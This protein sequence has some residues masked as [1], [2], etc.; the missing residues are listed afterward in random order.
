MTLRQQALDE[1]ASV[2]ERCGG[3][4]IDGDWSTDARSIDITEPAQGVRIGAIA[5]GGVE[6]VDRAVAAARRAFETG[7]WRTMAPGERTRIL[8]RAGDMIEARA[9]AI[10]RLE[11]LDV[12]MPHAKAMGLVCGTAEMFRYSAGWCTKLHGDAADMV[13]P[14]GIFHSYTRRE[15]AGVAALITPWNTPFALAGNKSATALS[16]GCTVVLKPAEDTPLSAMALAEVLREAGVPPGVFNLVNGRGDVVGAAL[17][18]HADVDKVGFTGSTAVGKRIVQAALGNMKRVTL[19]LGGKSPVVVF[20]DADI[21]RHAAT[22]A[23]GVFSN[24]GQMCVAGSRVFVHRS[25][26]DELVA[27]LAAYARGLKIGDGFAAETQ[28]GPL[29]SDRQLRRVEELVAAGVAEGAQAIAGGIRLDQPGFYF[30]PTVL[31]APKPGARILREE[32]FGPV[33]NVIPFEDEEEVVAAANDTDYGLAAAVYTGSAQRGHRLARRL[34][35]GTV[36]INTQLVMNPIMPFGGFRQSGW[37]REFGLAGVDAYTE[38][39][40]VITP[41]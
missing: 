41:A 40:T 27:A 4:L 14:T 30:T 36:W 3:H 7:P 13:M 15:P 8:W 17:A 21:A 24:S 32:I 23:N 34:R 11:T 35:A 2:L 9:D 5:G 18:S 37:G 1:A 6:E 16:A 26:H 29:I 31:T 25:R 12:G 39:K 28:I 38:L 19:E 10:A 33:V 22:I 20:D